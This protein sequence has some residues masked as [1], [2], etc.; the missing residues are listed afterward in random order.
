M[1]KEKKKKPEVILLVTHYIIQSRGFEELKS[2]STGAAAAV[3]MSLRPFLPAL[4][5]VPRTLSSACRCLLLTRFRNVTASGQS[6]PRGREPCLLV[7]CCTQ[8]PGQCVA[9]GE[10]YINI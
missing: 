5:R 4:P 10:C 3:P 6:A 1:F 7:R 9:R 8:N 2:K